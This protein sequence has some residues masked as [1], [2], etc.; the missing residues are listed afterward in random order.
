MAQSRW[1][2]WTFFISAATTATLLILTI[3]S[4][5]F[6]LTYT[7]PVSGPAAESAVS[8]TAG[9]VMFG[10]FDNPMFVGAHWEFQYRDPYW[11]LLPGRY[12]TA[13]AWPLWIP[14][15]ITAVLT[16]ALWPNPKHAIAGRCLKCDYDISALVGDDTPCPECGKVAR[17]APAAPEPRSPDVPD[18]TLWPRTGHRD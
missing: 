17:P 15:L 16:L 12:H 7:Y 10:A 11:V 8:L 6:F 2:R 1:K 14:A 13:T 18:A 9:S 4:G 3:A 5:W